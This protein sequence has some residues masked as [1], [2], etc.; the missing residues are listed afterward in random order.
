MTSFEQ[1]Y[2]Q[3]FKFTSVQ[4]QR[5]IDSA[6]RDLDIAQKDQFAEVKFTYC[7][8]AYIKRGKAVIAKKGGVKVRSVMRHHVKIL[9]KLS[10]LL[11]DPDILTIGN[12]MRMKRNKDLYDAGGIITKKEID[13]YIIFVGGIIHKAKRALK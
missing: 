1:E 9:N 8:Q 11:S 7:Y 12:V 13:D 2:F 10:E 5:Y 4:I 3:K 6:V